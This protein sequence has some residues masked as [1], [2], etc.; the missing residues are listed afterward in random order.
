MK[1]RENELT[2]HK[3]N[4]INIPKK[5]KIKKLKRKGESQRVCQRTRGPRTL[6]CFLWRPQGCWMVRLNRPSTYPG[7][8]VLL[9]LCS[10][11][12][13]HLVD[14]LLGKYIASQYFRSDHQGFAVPSGFSGEFE[15]I[16]N[17]GPCL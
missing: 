16:I 3:R 17:T 12:I 15:C 11:L 9:V 1:N 7:T 5:N 2:N 14:F 4:M 8:T 10:Q 13:I 6:L